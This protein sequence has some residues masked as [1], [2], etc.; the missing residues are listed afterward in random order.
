MDPSQFLVQCSRLTNFRKQTSETRA[1]CFHHTGKYNRPA[2]ASCGLRQ[3]QW[4]DFP[5]WCT[6]ASCWRCQF[7]RS[8][9]S[10][11]LE[12][13]MRRI[14]ILRK[15]KP[16]RESRAQTWRAPQQLSLQ[17]PRGHLL[18]INWGTNPMAIDRE[19]MDLMFTSHHSASLFSRDQLLGWKCCL[20][21]LMRTFTSVSS[22]LS[23][24]W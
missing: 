15:C 3:G 21:A 12:L 18:V 22:H 19:N 24:T 9:T 14:K 10:N 1:A 13:K 11:Q 20:Y 5:W 6:R 2:I 4:S 23:A 17:R 8:A 7:S 16:S